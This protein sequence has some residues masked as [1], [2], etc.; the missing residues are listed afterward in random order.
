MTRAI[1]AV[2]VVLAAGCSTPPRDAP[3]RPL[4][5]G[6]SAPAYAVRT[7]AG[8][9][10]RVSAGQ[11]VLLNVWATWCTS[12]REE[13]ADLA[14]LDREYAPRG[15][16][17]LAVSVDVGDGT[18]VRRFVESEHLPFAVAHDPAG[19]VQKRFQAV[20]VPETYLISGDG[21]LLWVRRGGLHGAPMAVRA[22]LDSVVN[23]GR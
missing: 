19:V 3:F 2:V 5:V 14:T 21:R 17:V 1:V 4:V 22:T 18:R 16:R 7:L 15:V 12:C 23:S 13:M 9:S 20:G 10:V 8:D 11:P 6:D